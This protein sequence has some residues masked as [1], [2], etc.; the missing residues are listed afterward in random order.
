MVLEKTVNGSISQNP[1]KWRR[2]GPPHHPMV[3]GGL[4][5]GPRRITQR[6]TSKL[7]HKNN[8]RQRQLWQV[9]KKMTR[10]M[11]QGLKRPRNL[12]WPPKSVSAE[13]SNDERQAGY[14]LCPLVTVDFVTEWST[15]AP[16][17]I[18]MIIKAEKT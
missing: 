7:I 12:P 11:R 9:T 2:A 1:E 13:V 4:R 16:T 10:K 6:F 8:L 5:S 15:V 17:G 14:F 18:E 3:H